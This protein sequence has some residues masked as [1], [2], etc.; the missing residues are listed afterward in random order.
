M[1]RSELSARY[2]VRAGWLVA[3][4]VL[5]AATA[6]CST[7][8][9]PDTAYTCDRDPDLI[10][11]T[12][13]CGSTSDC[14]CGTHCA[15]SRCTSDCLSDE[16]CEGATCDAFG[17]CTDAGRLPPDA[18]SFFRVAPDALKLG[19]T[20]A[21]AR[22]R[23]G[24]ASESLRVKVDS[25]DGAIEVKCSSG[26]DFGSRCEL[27]LRAEQMPAEVEVRRRPGGPVAASSFGP[28]VRFTSRGRQRTVPVQLR[29]VATASTLSPG[30]Y[31][32]RAVLQSLRYGDGLTVPVPAP[33]S[34]SVMAH[35]GP[36]TDGRRPLHLTDSFRWLGPATDEGRPGS[37]MATFTPT[38]APGRLDMIP[39][40]ATPVLFGGF[41]GS[42]FAIGTQPVA[43]TVIPDD[44][45][46]VVLELDQRLMFGGPPGELLLSWRIVLEPTEENLA[47][48][49]GLVPAASWQPTDPD[50]VPT[51]VA[52][53][54]ATFAPSQAALAD[55]SDYRR[56][57]DIVCGDGQT[58][59]GFADR[60]GTVTEVLGTTQRQ[61]ARFDGEIA[62]SDGADEDNLRMRVFPQ[63]TRETL[64]PEEFPQLVIDCLSDLD[65]ATNAGGVPGTGRCLDSPRWIAAVE[66]AFRGLHS[67]GIADV[68]AQRLGTYLVSRW[69]DIH[70]LMTETFRLETYHGHFLSDFEVSPSPLPSVL[71]AVERSEGHWDA[72]LHPRIVRAIWRT[73]DSVLRAPDYRQVLGADELERLGASNNV[74]STPLPLALF[75]DLADQSALWVELSQRVRRGEFP[76]GPERLRAEDTLGGALR[77]ALTLYAL[78]TALQARWDRDRRPDQEHP[79]AVDTLANVFALA[80]NIETVRTDLEP[81]LPA[82]DVLT[83]PWR[84]VGDASQVGARARALSEWM[85]G[86]DAGLAGVVGTEIAEADR[87][88]RLAAETYRLYRLEAVGLRSLRDQAQGRI[89]YIRNGVG[90]ELVALCGYE[91]DA[92]SP[93]DGYQVFQQE[94]SPAN[95]FIDRTC[96][97]RS[98]ALSPDLGAY[99]TCVA[100]Y[101]AER[102]APPSEGLSGLTTLPG[103]DARESFFRTVEV[104]VAAD[105]QTYYLQGPSGPVEVPAAELD[106]YELELRFAGTPAAIFAAASETCRPA[107]EARTAAAGA[108]S[109]CTPSTNPSTSEVDELRAPSCNIDIASP[110]LADQVG[111][112]YRGEL[113]V[114]FREI[115]TQQAVVEEAQAG[116]KRALDVYTVDAG[117]C[118]ILAEASAALE[119]LYGDYLDSMAALRQSVLIA[120]VVV[121]TTEST[122]TCLR[123][124]QIARPDIP[125][126]KGIITLL[127]GVLNQIFQAVLAAKVCTAATTLA[128]QESRLAEL[129]L[130]IDVK[131]DKLRR[132]I[133]TLEAETEVGVCFN[134]LNRRA[135]EIA[136]AIARLKTA[137]AQLRVATTGFEQLLDRASQ[138]Y[139][140][141]KRWEQNLLTRRAT[142]IPQ[143]YRHR[144][145]FADYERQLYRVRRALLAANRAVMWELQQS[146]ID[147][148]AVAGSV[149][150]E[151]LRDRAFVLR[152]AVQ[153]GRVNGGNPT[154]G[155]FVLSLKRDILQ[156]AESRTPGFHRLSLDDQLYRRLT[157]PTYAVFNPDGTFAGQS[158][159]FSLT[160]DKLVG[161]SV[162]RGASDERADGEATND[163]VGDL[164]CGERLWSVGAAVA[165]REA[166]GTDGSRLLPLFLRKTN[167]SAYRACTPEAEVREAAIGR[168]FLGEEP[169]QPEDD[170]TPRFTAAWL[171]APVYRTD[172]EPRVR[173]QLETATLDTTASTELAG[174]GLY[175]TYELF[176]PASSLD[177]SRIDLREVKDIFL[178]VELIGVTNNAR[179]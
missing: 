3:I 43:L 61:V 131:Q 89:D 7:P 77:R 160:P 145:R 51:G 4:G 69:L 135:A 18:S 46:R 127:A 172:F 87:L 151:F 92:E 165:S 95:C 134:N 5:G 6:G 57:Q 30:S 115:L 16:D 63:I 27:E 82:T 75:S 171:N 152:Q 53:A 154:Q 137:V 156:L 94:Q 114:A 20:P 158:I 170:S 103:G 161:A 84:P 88:Y 13:A 11:R 96:V 37:P 90:S 71:T 143:D 120:R 173:A 126:N 107:Y 130:A 159:P 175:G 76:A 91:R 22:V 15:F 117:S 110:S 65:E 155:R 32:G 17:R 70:G 68:D 124:M 162:T 23:I 123:S 42:S 93:I 59:H 81:P 177:P 62:C 83:L 78:A 141:G 174:L 66:T 109:A 80:R 35:V 97:Q 121:A 147:P 39:S 118:V 60:L 12:I 26:Q 99:R 64:S 56:T 45:G 34:T 136:P 105:T 79:W 157:S 85:L 122:M 50:A 168:I 133:D 108:A 52:A 111:D 8:P 129:E 74:Q 176:I 86:G 49:A 140:E 9:E 24:N 150:L 178:V 144:A 33:V 102:V 139:A 21:V 166:L 167:R 14:P 67:G 179:F 28:A 48:P 164:L 119:Q 19:N 58:P 41:A 153:V 116:L 31:R 44:D 132:D 73:P 2:P 148:A 72:L 38:S 149:D 101:L 36:L 47:P 100:G 112:C 163:A 146:L 128:T 113:G 106:D 55:T 169:G 98:V 104:Q 10:G 25:L 1:P 29:V 54:L 40:D 142:A 138:L 125:E